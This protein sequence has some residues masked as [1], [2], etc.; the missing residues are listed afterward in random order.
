MS[1]MSDR[2]DRCDRCDRCDR[3][4]R[5]VCCYWLVVRD[6]ACNERMVQR[7]CSFA[8]VKKKLRLNQRLDIGS[9]FG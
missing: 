1:D 4:D 2:S 7:Q 6:R 5:F 3:S 9:L 8:F